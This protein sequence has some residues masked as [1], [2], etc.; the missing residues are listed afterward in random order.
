[1]NKKLNII[2]E[3]AIFT[4]ICFVFDYISSKLFGTVFIN[5]GSI[6]IQL[7]PVIILTL[8][9]GIISGL[10]L[11]II[12]IPLSIISGFYIVPKNIFLQIIQVLLDYILPYFL[13]VIS[14]FFMKKYIMELTRDNKFFKLYL[15]ISIPSILKFICVFLSGLI[16]ASPTNDLSESL[17]FFSSSTISLGPILY[18]LIYNFSYS[19]FSIILTSAVVVLIIKKNNKLV[20]LS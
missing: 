16:W 5:G 1:M 12:M 2:I 11:S 18:S 8:R 3:I 15:I 19:F 4:A 14:V 10:L 7:V 13:V 6:S 9:R 20:F 17:S